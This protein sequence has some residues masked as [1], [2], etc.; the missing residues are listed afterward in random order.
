MSVKLLVLLTR[1]SPSRYVGGDISHIG[2]WFWPRVS[3]SI[4]LVISP[5]RIAVLRPSASRSALAPFSSHLFELLLSVL[6]RL[7]ILLDGHELVLVS[8]RRPR[9]FLDRIDIPFVVWRLGVLCALLVDH[10]VVLLLLVLDVVAQAGSHVLKVLVAGVWREV[11]VRDRTSILR[12]LWK[13]RLWARGWVLN[14]DVL[15]H[16]YLLISQIPD[17]LLVSVRFNLFFLGHHLPCHERAY[18]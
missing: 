1:V 6:S 11:W 9:S 16:L 15:S 10:V 3:G 12:V 5:T 18:E 8:W 2:L 7:L 4:P 17:V 13:S 14:R